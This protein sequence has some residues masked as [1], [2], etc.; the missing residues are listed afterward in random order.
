MFSLNNNNVKSFD[1]STF[2]G[3]SN[4]AEL[5]LHN[6]QLITLPTEIFK[7]LRNL[8]YLDLSNNKVSVLNADIFS[9]LSKVSKL[10]LEGNNLSDIPVNTFGK[11]VLNKVCF[12]FNPLAMLPISY[13]DQVI[14]NNRVDCQVLTEQSC[15]DQNNC[16]IP[17]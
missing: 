16:I 15:C 13:L 3:L 17:N 8:L 6:N 9:S 10:G 5:R 4:L 2:F 11:M 7:D 12:K 14:C 1:R